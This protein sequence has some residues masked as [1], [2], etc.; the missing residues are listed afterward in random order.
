[1][2]GIF[3]NDGQLD[4]G[5]ADFCLESKGFIF[6]A[7]MTEP[8]STDFTIPKT[9]KNV[10]LLGASGLL[11]FTTQPLG[12][13]LE[14]VNLVIGGRVL[15]AM[16][17]VVNVKENSIDI[18]LFQRPL[19]P[20]MDKT[21]SQI[22]KDVPDVSVYYW[23]YNS[24]GIVPDVFKRYIASEDS[25][26]NDRYYQLHPTYTMNSVM[27]AIENAEG[28]TMPRF[29]DNLCLMASQAYVCPENTHQNVMVA[30][31]DSVC[32]ITASQHI[33]NDAKG[34]DGETAIESSDS[35]G[36]TFNRHCKC[37][38]KGDI[39]W[40]KRLALRDQSFTLGLYINDV[41]QSGVTFTAAMGGLANG[42]EHYY[43]HTFELNE[44]DSLS[45]K[46]TT[47]TGT[48]LRTLS[49]MFQ[50]DYI[51]GSYD[52][53]DDD[54]QSVNLV[55]SHSDAFIAE[56]QSGGSIVKH[57]YR[58]DFSAAIGIYNEVGTQQYVVWLD[59]PYRAMSYIGY[60]SSLPKISLKNL[61][62]SLAWAL[63]KRLVSTQTGVDMVD[64]GLTQTITAQI[65]CISP[66]SDSLGQKN[67]ILWGDGTAAFEWNIDNVWLVDEKV[68]HQ[69]LLARTE[70]QN[71]ILY[72]PQY[73]VRNGKG[74]LWNNDSAVICSSSG[75]TLTRRFTTLPSYNLTQLRYGVMEIQCY[76]YDNINDDS[77]FIIIDG[78]KFWIVEVTTDTV[79]GRS[80]ITAIM[81][82]Q[83]I[84]PDLMPWIPIVPVI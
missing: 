14:P 59:L 63:G 72:I 20:I 48:S 15:H 22:V 47:S 30:Y 78:R 8:F 1:M 74:D 13:A 39:I 31:R 43:P 18:C 5:G 32:V 19:P 41:Y 50:I 23:D 76:T 12:T 68:I 45:W 55:Y 28:Y 69:S 35:N 42:V 6:N 81:V 11:D 80:D 40:R 64:I 38:I 84:R 46:L 73:K 51:E 25:S 56:E 67:K 10:F 65:T 54:Y 37:N 60:Y 77:D 16:I 9:E 82:P 75:N 49:C 71:G 79:T 36:F 24:E 66:S 2:T 26:D 4:M 21:I 53:T 61:L 29:D 27:E 34:W 33:T 52:I 83:A 44:G 3:L 58:A 57:Y 70:Q 62:R 7:D 17:Q